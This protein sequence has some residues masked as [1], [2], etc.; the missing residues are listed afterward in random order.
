[1]DE[2]FN[3]LINQTVELELNIADLYQ[4]FHDQQP[5]DSDFWWKL[6]LE[7]KNHAAIL[8]A[9]VKYFAPLGRFPKTL[10]VNSLGE[11]ENENSK[12]RDIIDRCRE[13]PP[14]RDEAFRVAVDLEMSG[15]EM[16]YQTFMSQHAENKAAEVFR[17]LNKE[18]KDH[19]DRIIC[20]MNDNNIPL[21]EK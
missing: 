4:L 8:R 10:L 11:I 9:G 2:A 20:Y 12:V 6:S 16:H 15:A 21:L 18:D 7:E 17:R 19:I 13:N 1:M 14:S 3:R 5:S